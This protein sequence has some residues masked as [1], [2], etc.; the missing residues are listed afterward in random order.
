[1]R[2]LDC[3]D[4]ERENRFIFLGIKVRKKGK[5]RVLVNLWLIE[6]GKRYFIFKNLKFFKNI[7]GFYN[8]KVIYVDEW[9]EECLKNWGYII[10]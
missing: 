4:N 8:I 7:I 9:F 1:M 3:R 6:E 5:W 10:V 2:K